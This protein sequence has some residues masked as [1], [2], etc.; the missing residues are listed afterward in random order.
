MDLQLD[1]LCGVINTM[2]ILLHPALKMG[3]QIF[4]TSFIMLLS[5]YG[6]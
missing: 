2:T 1:S 5:V 6:N 3:V 4:L